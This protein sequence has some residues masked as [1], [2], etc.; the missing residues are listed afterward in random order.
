MSKKQ[1]KK[2]PETVSETGCLNLVPRTPESHLNSLIY[3]AQTLDGRLDEIGYLGMLDEPRGHLFDAD[4]A[5]AQGESPMRHLIRAARDAGS[6]RDQARNLA[7]ALS[8]LDA[9]FDE[10]VSLAI[11]FADRG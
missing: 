2:A 10:L 1:T 11:E 4:R 8:R 9:F 6:I 5:V 3:Y 7:E